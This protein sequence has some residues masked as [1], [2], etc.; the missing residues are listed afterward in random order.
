M[1][2]TNRVKA[3]SVIVSQKH[4]AGGKLH[5]VIANS[6]NANA[7]TG[8]AGL[9]AARRMAELAADEFA[10]SPETV[11]VA[12][13]GVIGVPLPIAAIENSIAALAG[14]L[15][16]DEAGHSAALEAIM[17]TDTRK[18]EVSIEMEN[19]ARIGGM[20]KGSGMIHPNMATMLC[21]LT[22][23]VSISRGL[24][25]A[26]LRRAVER[27]FN[28]VTVDGDT[29]TNDMALIMANGASGVNVAEGS[30]EYEAFSQALE[31][32]CVSL[33][34]A[35]ARDGEGATKL[36]TVSVNGAANEKTAET[37]AKSVASSSLVKAACFGADANWGRILCAMGY[38]GAEFEP[39]ATSVSF[40]SKAGEIAVFSKGAPVR[41]F[42]DVAKK[43]LS[44][45]EI[46]IV[47]NAGNGSG[48]ATA[49]GCDLT[50]DYVKINGDYRS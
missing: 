36:V 32:C 33:A 17:T 45:E 44:E 13:T 22:T 10:V 11:A 19:K 46:E 41:F 50:Y 6:G 29:S 5:A 23:D 12:S 30:A 42:E 34:R 47:I 4:I 24:L 20:A 40:K 26:S 2:T 28:R 21:F 39:D 31:S 18:K 37:L 16:G 35:M 7:C 48:S 14:S 27:S 3:A 43:V 15:R 9:A 25:E 8:E 38:S 1:F 49:W